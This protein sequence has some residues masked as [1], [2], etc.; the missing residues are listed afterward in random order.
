MVARGPLTG[1]AVVVADID[2]SLADDKTR[3][4]GTDVFAARRP[5][6]YGPLLRGAAR[7]ARTR[8]AT[9]S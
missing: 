4:D 9:P 8:P 1:E 5:E 3:P 2:V 7:A 6:A